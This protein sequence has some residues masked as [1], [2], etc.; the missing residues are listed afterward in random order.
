[1]TWVWDMK[2]SVYTVL[3]GCAVD[4]VA[5]IRIRRTTHESH[6]PTT[7]TA[8]E[9]NNKVKKKKKKRKVHPELPLTMV[10]TGL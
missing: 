9:I 7:T 3:R 2:E 5:R 6:R 8:N 1:M 10:A 4:L